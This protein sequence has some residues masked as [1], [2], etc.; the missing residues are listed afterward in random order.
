MRTAR[1]GLRDLTRR[2]N[3]ISAWI[4]WFR[5]QGFH[6]ERSVAEQLISVRDQLHRDR[7]ILR[8]GGI[9]ETP[10][11]E[12]QR[13]DV[14]DDY[15][16]A[17]ALSNV[18]DRLFEQ[19]VPQHLTYDQTRQ[20]LEGALPR[21]TPSIVTCVGASLASSYDI[22]GRVLGD[23][24]ATAAR[25]SAGY[26]RVR[27]A[28]A[29]AR[30]VGGSI[31][32]PFVALAA[33]GLGLVRRAEPIAQPPPPAEPQ[34]PPAAPPQPLN[35]RDFMN[36]PQLRGELVDLSTHG[37]YNAIENNPQVIEALLIGLMKG[38][39]YLTDAQIRAESLRRRGRRAVPAP[40]PV[41]AV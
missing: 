5:G 34:P 2:I 30:R 41:P 28:V 26:L 18:L 3:L 35:P 8:A 16:P 14:Y 36:W 1:R 38:F 25:Y 37:L 10:Q 23:L 17:Q 24:G 39:S 21:W 19:Y 20:R 12:G 11:E 6:F 29:T 33:L 27:A 7:V 31:G 4:F 9:F 15:N 13:P 40:V 32:R 22:R